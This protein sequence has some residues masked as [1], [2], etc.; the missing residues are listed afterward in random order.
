M[1]NV[2]IMCGHDQVMYMQVVFLNLII[3]SDVSS[4]GTWTKMGDELI[5]KRGEGLRE[6][7]RGVQGGITCVY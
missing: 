6:C 2:D 1:F 3:K 4:W 7:I 5:H